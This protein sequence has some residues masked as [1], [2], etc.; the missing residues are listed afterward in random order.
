MA[1]HDME[2]FA[3]WGHEEEEIDV[4]D[5]EE[6]LKGAYIKAQAKE[7]QKRKASEEPDSELAWHLLTGFCY[8]AYNARQVVVMCQLAARDGAQGALLTQ[9][10]STEV[11]NA[12]R[13]VNQALQRILGTDTHQP[14]VREIPLKVDKHLNDEGE[15]TSIVKDIGNSRVV[16]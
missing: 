11:H 4:A 9:L 7:P 13:A 12:P 5:W 6:A 15:L 8:G 10:A 1:Q 14:F 2:M 3:A 16:L